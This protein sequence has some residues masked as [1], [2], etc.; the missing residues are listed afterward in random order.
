MPN[1]TGALVTNVVGSAQKSLYSFKQKFPT[2]GTESPVG[3]DK[4]ILLKQEDEGII[5]STEGQLE[6]LEG[7]MPPHIQPHNKIDQSEHTIFK[8]DPSDWNN[9]PKILY[10][11]VGTI[12]TKYDSN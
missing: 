1:T 8:M 12:I 6:D 5:E 2:T 11:S 7:N 4:K 10:D 3:Q 9:V